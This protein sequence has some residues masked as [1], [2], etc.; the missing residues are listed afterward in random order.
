MCVVNVIF[1]YV[2]VYLYV[3]AHIGT[4]NAPRHRTPCASCMK[5]SIAF[6]YHGVSRRKSCIVELKKKKAGS[7]PG[8]DASKDDSAELT[9]K[10]R[11]SYGFGHPMVK[12]EMVHF[13][14]SRRVRLTVYEFE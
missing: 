8:L 5:K 1:I 11:C 3:F 14:G 12:L 4:T 7:S 2:Y 6:S 9:G 13:S 10:A